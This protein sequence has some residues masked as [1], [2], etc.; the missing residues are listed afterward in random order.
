[1]TY[2]FNRKIEEQSIEYANTHDMLV[3]ALEGQVYLKETFHKVNTNQVT[4]E[5]LKKVSV[6]GKGGFGSQGDARDQE[7]QVNATSRVMVMCDPSQVAFDH[8]AS[9]DEKVVGWQERVVPFTGHTDWT[10]VIGPQK[11]RDY[12]EFVHTNELDPSD[13]MRNCAFYL[14]GDMLKRAQDRYDELCGYKGAHL[15]VGL[16]GYEQRRY[17][18]TVEC[19]LN[20]KQHFTHTAGVDADGNIVV[21]K[22]KEP[23]KGKECYMNWEASSYNH[24]KQV[25]AIYNEYH[26]NKHDDEWLDEK[27]RNLSRKDCIQ[28]LNWQFGKAKPW[29]WREERVFDNTV[30]S[31]PSEDFLLEQEA[32]RSLEKKRRL[33]ALKNAPD[34]SDWKVVYKWELTKQGKVMFANEKI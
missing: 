33:D 28:F 22:K 12:D 21:R 2:I 29:D 13:H 26:Y 1:M 6:G 24:N 15:Y 32:A 8:N 27:M 14:K 20:Q 7:K 3:E 18:F 19:L 10:P 34:L 16:N 31:E 11:P 23:Y 17:R 25:Y 30:V 9:L 4:G 5:A